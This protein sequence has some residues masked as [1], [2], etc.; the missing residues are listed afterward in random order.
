MRWEE[1]S[2]EYSVRDGGRG[3]QRVIGSKERRNACMEL[4][5]RSFVIRRC[6]CFINR[7]R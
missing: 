6:I 7:L 2:M 1:D 5:G 4:R 3:W